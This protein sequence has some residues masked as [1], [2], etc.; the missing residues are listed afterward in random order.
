MTPLVKEPPRVEVSPSNI[1]VSEGQKVIFHCNVSGIPSTGA[2]WTKKGGTLPETT[3]QSEP[4]ILRIDSVSESDQGTY[5]CTA[6]NSEGSASGH[7]RLDVM[8]TYAYVYV[9]YVTFY[10]RYVT[11]K[12]IHYSCYREYKRT[13]KMRTFYVR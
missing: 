2:S 12:C 4:G 3:V 5:I 9:R 7:V 10:V 6:T 8:G 1:T 13:R 11:S